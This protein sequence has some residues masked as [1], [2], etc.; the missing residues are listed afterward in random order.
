MDSSRMPVENIQE[1]KSGRR[2]CARSCASAGASA[3]VVR[4]ARLGPTDGPHGRQSSGPF[5]TFKFLDATVATL[6]G[7]HS[8]RSGVPRNGTGSAGPSCPAESAAAPAI[9]REQLFRRYEKVRGRANGR[10]GRSVPSLSCLP[11]RDQRPT[12]Q[13]DRADKIYNIS[14]GF[15]SGA[16]LASTDT[17]RHTE[18]DRIALTDT[19]TDTGTPT[20]PPWLSHQLSQLLRQPIRSRRRPTQYSRPRPAPRRRRPAAK[21]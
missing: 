10:A 1:N 6:C 17:D 12:R 19:G 8:S 18:I 13:H 16:S 5:P 20:L 14:M 11:H 2:I 4:P 9:G 7:V 21:K 3:G 15:E